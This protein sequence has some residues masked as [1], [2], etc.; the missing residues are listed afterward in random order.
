MPG[1]RWLRYRR[2]R[3]ALEPLFALP[4]RIRGSSLLRALPQRGGDFEHAFR[5]GCIRRVD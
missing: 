2:L 1:V 5:N 3:Y 4:L